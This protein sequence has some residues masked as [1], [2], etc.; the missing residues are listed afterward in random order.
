MKISVVT[1]T[2]NSAATVA[3]TL[4]SVN[5]QTHPDVE[6]IVIDGGSTDATL[7][8]VRSE[9]RR[10]STLV[11]EPDR[12]IY[13]AMNKGLRLATG[14][15]VGL[16]NSDDFLAGDDILATVVATFAA[17]PTLE[18]V[19]GD[20][21]YVSPADTQ[22]VVR[23]WRS[24]P[25]RPGLFAQGWAPPHPTLYVRRSVYDRLGGFDLTYPLAADLELMARFLEVHR[26]RAVHVPKVFVR[27][28]TGGATNKNLGNVMRQNCEIWQAL[29][30]HGLAR[31]MPRFAIAKLGSRLRQ[32][33]TRE[34]T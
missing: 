10:V 29:T 8:I 23:Y 11:S 26:V 33:V 25:F 27:M 19:Y 3:D 31:S 14:E 30:K 2:W 32:F 6:H 18:A 5:T 15:V 12:G 34:S 1:V 21:C 24:S 16:I 17:D 20:L 28:R 4:R 22:R 7:D 9:G 13:D